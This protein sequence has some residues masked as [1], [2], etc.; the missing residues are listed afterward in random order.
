MSTRAIVER[1]LEQGEGVIRMVP[2]WVPR[3]FCIPGR[4]I[5]L[6]PDDYYALGAGRGG[7]DERWFSSTTYA[8]NGP[9]TPEDEGLSYL[10]FEDG[11]SVEKVTML[12]AVAEMKGELIGDR[13]WD[14]YQGWP[15][16][17]K[18]FDNKGALP[19]HIHQREHHARLVGK[20]SKPEAYYFPPQMN[21]YGADFPYTFFGFQPGV[22]KEQ[23]V[24]CLQNFT[25]GDNRITDLSTAYR[26][27]PGTGWDIPAGILHAPGSFCTYE[28]QWASDIFAMYQSV[29]GDAVVDEA[30]LWKDIPP[31]K[32][33]DF[34]FLVELVDW[35]ANIDPNFEANHFM[36][37]RPVRPLAE[38]EAEGYC[39]KWV[40]YRSTAFSA[41]ELTVY[42]GRTVTINDEA[43]YS[44]IMVQ[45][46]GRMG[47]WPIE[48]PT[49]IRF[50]QLT[51][52]EFFVSEAAARAGVSIHNPS[53]TEPIVMLKNF[54]PQNPELKIS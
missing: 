28:P 12:E 47:V 22:T 19:F 10:V 50:G 32:N 35:E 17:A 49:L 38:M 15:V 29:T 8:D 23:L 27:A 18:F 14:Q 46:H 36:E 1:A 16:Y 6:H 30:L 13:L 54:G 25:K 40:C 21:N 11:N 4:R 24:A 31:E 42:P 7:I 45:G 37:P 33:G 9:G 26:L 51:H 48:T 34:D 53:P 5:K 43:A 44:L 3:S 52:D 2:T 41:K 39:E 20:K